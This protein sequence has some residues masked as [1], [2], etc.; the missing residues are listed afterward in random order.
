MDQMFHKPSMVV[1]AK[2]LHTEKGSSYPT[3]MPTP[4]ITNHWLSVVN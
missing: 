1:P 4:V 3:G 2:A